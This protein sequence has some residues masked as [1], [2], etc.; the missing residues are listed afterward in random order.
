MAGGG[1]VASSRQLDE[2]R[3][4]LY[5]ESVFLFQVL[6]QLTIT[7]VRGVAKKKRKGEGKKGKKRRELVEATERALVS[8]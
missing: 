1:Y 8:I 4:R 5:K 6:P 2:R 7:D 3:T